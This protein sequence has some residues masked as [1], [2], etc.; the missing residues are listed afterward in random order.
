MTTD[1]RDNGE[2]T[3]HAAGATSPVRYPTAIAVGS[4]LAAA[5][6]SSFIPMNAIEGFVSAYGIAELLPAAAPPLGNTA[7]LALSTGIGTLTAGAL[8]ALLPREETDVMGFEAALKKNAASTSPG[9]EETAV[10]TGFGA[11][12]LAGWLRTLRFGKT[13]AAEGEITDFAELG[14]MRMRTGDQHPDAPVRAPIM[15]SSDL[16]EPLDAP[17]AP[18]MP[19]AEPL[20][21]DADMAIVPPEP[22]VPPPSLRF[23][24]P[25][26]EPQINEH[27]LDP[28]PEPVAVEHIPAPLE[29][30]P[31]QVTPVAEEVP[32]TAEI[33][34]DRN[35]LA[36]LGI[37]ALLDRLESGLARRREQSRALPAD[38]GPEAAPLRRVIPLTLAPA[39][40]LTDEAEPVRM[41]LGEPPV[42][43]PFQPAPALAPLDKGLWDDAIEY[44]PPSVLPTSVITPAIA[45]DIV[46]STP[47]DAW[48][49]DEPETAG[50][51]VA[52][53][54]DMD[55]ALRDALATLRQ[56]SDRQ[57]NL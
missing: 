31:E 40:D 30:H 24:P 26:E 36:Q 14:R 29:D 33:P 39:P 27:A 49:D 5:V 43:H 55:A 57:R 34:L 44:H 21:L 53:E 46:S 52:A 50:P 41:R 3:G 7:R 42:D 10:A 8:L 23:A 32:V 2:D 22:F 6:G 25:V 38:G 11:T 48:V 45:D 9:E 16:G 28:A 54:D 51:A 37:A 12:K 56:L 19:E 18:V 20:A 4:G 15:A 13:E 35:D 1:M 17:P 47:S